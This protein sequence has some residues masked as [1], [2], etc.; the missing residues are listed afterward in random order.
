M[1]NSEAGLAEQILQTAKGMFIHKGY[2]G[3]SMREI[4][5]SLGV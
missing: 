1:T 3:L 5:E 4:S 2:Y